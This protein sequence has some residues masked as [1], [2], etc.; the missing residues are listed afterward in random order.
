MIFIFYVL[1]TLAVLYPLYTIANPKRVVLVSTR[2]EVVLPV[3]DQILKPFQNELPNY[4]FLEIG[5]G[6]G[7][8]SQYIARQKIFK[9]VH[10]VEIDRLVF[11]VAKVSLFLK[12]VAVNYTRANILKY[13]IEKPAFIYSYMSIYIT[14]S[15]YK[16]NKLEGSVFISLSFPITDVVPT[17]VYDIK[18]FQKKLYVYDFRSN[19]S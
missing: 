16:A 8:V 17:E 6:Y 14:D 1:V 2:T 10:A 4:N 18:G 3:L 9:S 13:T 7:Q 15:L 19:I 5:A 11:I 12:K